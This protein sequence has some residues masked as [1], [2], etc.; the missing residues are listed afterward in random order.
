M[1]FNRDCCKNLTFHTSVI[2]GFPTVLT[3]LVSDLRPM[4]MVLLVFQTL[5]DFCY[6]RFS[7]EEVI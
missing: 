5:P 3:F 4:P 1:A 6:S 2:E 7:Q